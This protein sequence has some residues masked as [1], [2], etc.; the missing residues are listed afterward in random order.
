MKL[1]EKLHQ[2]QTEVDRFVKDGKGYDYKY[3]KGDTVLNKIRPLM[4]ELKLILKQ[5]VVEVVN[6]REDYDT[7]NGSKSEMFTSVKQLFTW[8]DVE[9]GDREEVRWHANGQNS[10]DKGFG[11]A[12]TYAERYFLLKFFHIPTDEDDPDIR[13]DEPAYRSSS[14]DDDKKWLNATDKDG[15][16]NELGRKTA[17]KLKS[18]QTDWD[19]IQAVF[20]VSKK[21]RA[22]IM[23]EV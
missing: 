18:G 8:I 4:N 5:E 2:I 14:Q 1:L 19:K 21:D 9:T 10:W 20:K 23:R 11:S 7:R 15:T 22:A 16:L 17:E 13:I 6:H 12:L 3:T